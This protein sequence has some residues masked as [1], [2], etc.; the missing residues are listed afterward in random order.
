MYQALLTTTSSW[1]I[2][3]L[4]FCPLLALL[5]QPHGLPH[6][7]ETSS[8]GHLHWLFILPR[9]FFPET[10]PYCYHPVR[11]TAKCHFLKQ[12]L[13]VQLAL[14]MSLCLNPPCQSW[15]LRPGIATTQ[16]NP[17]S[18]QFNEVGRKEKLPIKGNICRVSTQIPLELDGDKHYH[19]PFAEHLLQNTDCGTHVSL[20]IKLKVCK[21]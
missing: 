6:I 3:F 10:T 11:Q 16:S 9:T 14:C 17:N 2:H 1:R 18:H 5:Q 21:L 7:R 13:W 4:L 20:T 15:C 8:S 19:F 12:T